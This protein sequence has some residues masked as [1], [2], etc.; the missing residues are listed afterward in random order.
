[1][2]RAEISE[3]VFSSD[4][5]AKRGRAQTVPSFKRP[6]DLFLI[7]LSLPIVLLIMALIAV[8]IRMTSPGPVFFR[9]T[10]VGYRG[11]TF[12]MFKFR[13]MYLDAE[14]RLDALRG[15]SD[16]DGVCFKLRNDPRVTA[17]GRILRRTSLDE[18]PQLINVVRGEMSLV[19]PR[20]ALPCEVATY[21]AKACA[22]L[23]GLPGLTGLWQVKGRAD[24][25]FDAMVD[26]DIEYLRSCSLSNDL[27]ILAATISAVTSGRGAY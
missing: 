27:K 20:P 15:Q 24:V 9:Q 13:S 17:V 1:M 5:T 3:R 8:A 11:A 19:G 12:T 7:L 22:R 18:L 2:L 10:R 23:A 14:S 16:R 25:P 21:S 4:Q 26:L 6:L